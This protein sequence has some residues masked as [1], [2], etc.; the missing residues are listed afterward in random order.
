[1][2]KNFLS[3][4]I[5][6]KLHSVY[7]I[8]HEKGAGAERADRPCWAVVLKYTGETVYVCRGKSCV[9]DFRTMALL[10]KGS[11]YRWTCTKAGYVYIAE[12][13]C[14]LT[15]D[16]ICSLPVGCGD[17]ILQLFKESENRLNTKAPYGRLAAFRNM[18]ALFSLLAE[19]GRQTYIPSD[20]RRKLAPAID[21]IGKNLNRRLYNDE[22]AAVTGL[23]TVY[24]RRLFTAAY[25]LSPAA[26]IQ[27]LRVEKAKDMLKSDYGSITDIAL[28][29]GYAD[30][31]DFS[32]VFKRIV[33]VAPTAYARQMTGRA[34][35]QRQ[36]KSSRIETAAQTESSL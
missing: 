32:R 17:K 30:I 26:Y 19:C 18:Y 1:M 36:G 8:Y 31:Y 24:F 14:N 11:A 15:A 22:L 4:L 13:D 29:L 7:S 10:P 25:G 27:R 2:D 6:T 12:F 35:G 34:D 33:G 23:S 28:S 3:D 16:D 21:Y 20:Q 9:S 5:I